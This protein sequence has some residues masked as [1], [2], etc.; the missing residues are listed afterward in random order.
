MFDKFCDTL[1]SD[2]PFITVEVNPPH[3]ASINTII[4]DIKKYDLD[5]KISGFSCTDNPLAKLKMSGILS[6]IKIQ[7]TLMLEPRFKY[8]LNP[9]CF[10]T[11]CWPIVFILLFS[12][13]ECYK[14]V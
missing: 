7:Q 3:G 12:W 8:P 1:C 9:H 11:A 5:K 4:E 13:V 6:A 2:K 10:M 14:Y